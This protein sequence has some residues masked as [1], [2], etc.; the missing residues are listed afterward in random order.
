M[1][2]PGNY[3]L[4]CDVI[5]P[6]PDGRVRDDWRKQRLWRA[7]TEFLVEALGD[8]TIIQMVG[9]RWRRL[10]DIRPSDTLVYEKL[11]ASLVPTLEST[12][13]FLFRLDITDQGMAWLLRSGRVSRA[14]FERLVEA[15]NADAAAEGYLPGPSLIEVVYR[16]V[17]EGSA[18]WC[19]KRYDTTIGQFTTEAAARTTAAILNASEITT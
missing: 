4:P 2:P 15:Y 19:V 8:I 9:S 14:L 17:D 1:I 7:G 11:A 6:L 3:I 18:G 5:N 12:D 10:N 13:A 16:A